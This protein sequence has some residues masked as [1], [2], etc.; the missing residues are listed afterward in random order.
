MYIP[1]VLVSSEKKYAKGIYQLSAIFF[2][3]R[4][5]NICRILLSKFETLFLIKISQKC[6]IKY[7]VRDFVVEKNYF[8]YFT[9]TCY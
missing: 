6:E 8:K 3:Q 1:S 9:K 7:F 2:E 5:I 4:E